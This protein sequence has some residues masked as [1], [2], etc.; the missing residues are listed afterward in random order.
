[1]FVRTRLELLENQMKRYKW[2]Q[3]QIKHMKVILNIFLYYTLF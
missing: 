3:D 1:M 2:E